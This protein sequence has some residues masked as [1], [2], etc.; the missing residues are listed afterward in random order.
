MQGKNER[1]E[2]Y[3][4]KI[5]IIRLKNVLK[6]RKSPDITLEDKE[7]PKMPSSFSD[8]CRL[9]GI[10]PAL[11]TLCFLSETLL[12]ESEFTSDYQLEI[13]SELGMEMCIHISFQLWNSIFTFNV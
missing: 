7:P 1:R 11:R 13:A 12:E 6:R 3:S 4:D 10:Q 5:T 2:K 9:L 8:A